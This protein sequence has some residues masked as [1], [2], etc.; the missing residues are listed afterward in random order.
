MRGLLVSG[1]TVYITVKWGGQEEAQREK[2]RTTL[3]SLHWSGLHAMTF[4]FLS[5]HS[6]QSQE[7]SINPTDCYF[8]T[9]T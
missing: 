3:H 1:S 7:K 4:I 9:P 6:K 8:F 2:E 5:P